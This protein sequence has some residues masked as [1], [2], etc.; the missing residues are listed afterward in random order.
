MKFSIHLIFISGTVEE[1]DRFALR[2]DR[3]KFR[4][5]SR[6]QHSA[7]SPKPKIPS[8]PQRQNRLRL[9]AG[10][11]IDSLPRRIGDELC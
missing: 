11:G 7:L 4:G 10:D 6:L 1:E 5:P 8:R 9:G 3:R 2:D